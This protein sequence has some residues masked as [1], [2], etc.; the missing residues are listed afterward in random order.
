MKFIFLL[1]V[2][3][4][5]SQ[6]FASCPVGDKIAR[7]KGMDKALPIY[8]NCALYQNDDDTQNYLAGIYEKGLGNISKNIN[9][10][11]LFYHLSAEN[12]NASSMVA[13]SD[14]L[15]QL[16]ETEDGR[17]QLLTYLKKIR[18]NLEKTRQTSFSG[19][20]LHP[21]ALLLLAAEKPDVKWFY[22]TTKK[23]DPRAAKLLKE[24]QIDD[25]KKEEIVRE[26]TQWKQRKMLDIAKEAFSPSEFRDFHQTIY[27][28]TGR[29]DA[30]KRSQAVNKLK[31]KIES[32]VK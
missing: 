5:S 27:P 19:Q 7:E 6:A 32:R 24:Y 12:G 3:V 17:Q 11:L 28:K 14:L 22:T 4:F 18:L 29:P 15:R 21:Y 8:V 30:F 9:R 31:E 16:D 2:F 13:L 20:L 23:S 25:V 10:A 1:F 26:A